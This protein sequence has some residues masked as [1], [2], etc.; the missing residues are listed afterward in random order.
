MKGGT[1]AIYMFDNKCFTKPITDGIYIEKVGLLKNMKWGLQYINILYIKRPLIPKPPLPSTVI[2]DQH[3]H[4]K[5]INYKVARIDGGMNMWSLNETCIH[6]AETNAEEWTWLKWVF[7]IWNE[8]SWIA[9]FYCMHG[10]SAWFYCMV[11]LHGFTAW[12]YCRVLKP[13]MGYMRHLIFFSVNKSAW[14]YRYHH[15]QKAF[16]NKSHTSHQFFFQE[17]IPIGNKKWMLEKKPGINEC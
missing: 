15:H 13:S 3:E 7:F 11:L 6:I 4:I 8:P 12:F 2:S 14:W 9:W 1:T 10:F 17:Y 16:R 5:N